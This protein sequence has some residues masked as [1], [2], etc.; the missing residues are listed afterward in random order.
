MARVT[1][2][3]L[4]GAAS[5]TPEAMRETL[6]KGWKPRE[7][8]QGLEKKVAKYAE[9]HNTTVRALKVP[10]SVQGMVADVTIF[11]DQPREL[12]ILQQVV[13]DDEGGRGRLGAYEA[14]VMHQL[15]YGLR[16]FIDDALDE[17]GH[18]LATTQQADIVREFNWR[19]AGHHSSQPGLRCSMAENSIR[20]GTDGSE[21]QV[22]D[23]DEEALSPGATDFTNDFSAS[24]VRWANASVTLQSRAN[25]SAEAWRSRLGARGPLMRED[26]LADA[27]AAS[28]SALVGVNPHRCRFGCKL[29]YDG[30]EAALLER[31]SHDTPYN[32]WV[33]KQK[34]ANR[35]AAL[36]KQ[37]RVLGGRERSAGGLNPSS[38]GLESNRTSLSGLGGG[39]AAPTAGLGDDGVDRFGVV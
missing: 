19:E 1:L 24:K 29:C 10:S 25:V 18:V 20:D 5:N 32:D 35:Q 8:V 2:P 9:F 15:R 22:G 30:V 13:A 28:A 31:R 17:V 16:D 37:K 26:L 33:R 4:A 38:S 34:T 6:R 23:N 11:S 3:E 12:Q 36:A 27:A 39:L 7:R 21:M 14:L